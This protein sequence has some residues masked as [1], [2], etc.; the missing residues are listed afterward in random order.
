MLNKLTKHCCAGEVSQQLSIGSESTTDV[1]DQQLKEASSK[2]FNAFNVKAAQSASKTKN[3]VLKK[4]TEKGA[5]LA[6]ATF[7]GGSPQTDSLAWCDSISS[8]PVVIAYTDESISKLL[9]ANSRGQLSGI[10][11]AKLDVLEKQIEQFVEVVLPA[12]YDQCENGQTYDKSADTCVGI[13][14]CPPGSE[15]GDPSSGKST[16]I[17]HTANTFG[18]GDGPKTRT[19]QCEKCDAGKYSPGGTPIAGGTCKS[20]E[21]GTIAAEA[22]AT[23]CTP[24]DAGFTSDEARTSCKKG[25][26]WKL[27]STGGGKIYWDPSKTWQAGCVL[28]EAPAGATNYVNNQAETGAYWDCTN[29][30]NTIELVPVSGSDPN[31]PKYKVTSKSSGATKSLFL[32]KYWEKGFKYWGVWSLT[33]STE[34]DV[35]TYTSG[36]DGT[37]PLNELTYTDAAGKRYYTVMTAYT[38]SSFVS[39][40]SCQSW[41]YCPQLCFYDPTEYRDI[42]Y[43]SYDEGRLNPVPK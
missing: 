22:G 36:T 43:G 33:Q 12:K 24:C 41:E 29:T 27:V 1:S 4:V 6:T 2:S 15:L 8:A 9:K 16:L 13:E 37:Y 7:K 23:K 30:D 17:R 42:K 14:G 20:C 39:A 26:T 11:V 38:R 31:K 25:G 19:T 32:Y 5:Q 18:D 34:F 28:S 35:D 40:L 10:P 3:E 21:E